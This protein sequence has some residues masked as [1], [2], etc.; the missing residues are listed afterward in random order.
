M[1]IGVISYDINFQKMQGFTMRNDFTMF[2]R[3][4]PSGAK[5][6][7]YYA[8]DENGIRKGPWTTKCLNFTEARNYC[9][10]LIKNG[11][12]IPNRIKTVTFS[13]FAKGFWEL[14]SDY[15]RDERS[16]KDFD[17]SYVIVSR[18]LSVCQIEPFFGKVSL[19]KITDEMVNKWLLGFK[20]RGKK[21][22]KTG[23]I[24]SYYKNSYANSAFRTLNVMLAEAVKRKL[25]P[26]NPCDNV[27]R[28]K[29][30]KKKI[31]ILKLDEVHKL[32]PKNYRSVWGDKEIAYAANLLASITGMRIGE[33]MG[34]RGEY[35]FDNYI[36]ICGQYGSYG[37][38]DWTKT[39][40]NRSIP[41]MPEM[42]AVL[43]KLMKDNGSGYVFSFTK[44]A[45]PAS[46][47]YVAKEFKNALQKIGISKTEIKQRGL[48][49]HS[50]RHFL[51]TELQRQ[52]LTISQVQSV[53]GHKSERMTEWYNHPD[54]MNVPNVTK[55]QAAIF[56]QVEE[57]DN[58]KPAQ[59]QN[60]RAFT[61]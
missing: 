21:D 5:V 19:D 22:P 44:G 14:D 42:I 39:K 33:I 55:A 59:Q 41:L 8:Y 54:P 26:F 18:Q 38:Q 43:R 61:P 37:Y 34:L 30:N 20:D 28:L 50:W 1:K 15:I 9:H 36:L 32:F 24:T 53:T 46:S 13:E 27:E 47:S 48:T 10:R 45:L 6:V 2:K 35:V 60:I 57:I 31:D 51:N 4:V 17:D 49:F 40:E 3:A 52:G 56:A 25:M 11:A 58:S 29:R 7:Y 23:E 16:R 12:L